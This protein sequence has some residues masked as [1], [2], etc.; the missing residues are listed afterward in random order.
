M[1]EGQETAVDTA[2]ANTPSRLEKVH[3]LDI[4]ENNTA[5]RPCDRKS[6]EYQELLASVKAQGV[7]QTITVREC[8]DPVT[9]AKFYGLIDG[10]QRFTAAKDAGLAELDVKVVVANDFEVLQKQLILNVQRIDTLPAQYGT[11]LKRMLS[12]NQSLTVLELANMIGKSTEFIYGRLNLT[13]LN[14]SVAKLVDEGKI[15]LANAYAL[16]KLPSEEQAAFVDR[17]M[18]QTP[19]EFVPQTTTRVQELNK[20]ARTG[21]EATPTVWTAQPRQRKLGELKAEYESPS[22]EAKLLAGVTDPIEAFRIAIKWA[23]HMDSI[24][25]A[26]AKAKEE[27]RVKEAEDAKAR[28]KAEKEAAEKAEAVAKNLGVA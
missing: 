11:Q 22:V 7:L 12:M 1:R 20:A 2:I 13:K 8:S 14:E 18:S 5:L 16:S 10:L 26:E 25:V 24:S 21:R 4:R 6:V 27:A 28:R 19:A 9:S 17:A 15:Q 23:V 3:I